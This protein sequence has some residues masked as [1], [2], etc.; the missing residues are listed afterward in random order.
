MKVGSSCAQPGEAPRVASGR[1]QKKSRRHD[2]RQAEEK[3]R[4]VLCHE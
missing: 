3:P 2:L 4:V 1:L